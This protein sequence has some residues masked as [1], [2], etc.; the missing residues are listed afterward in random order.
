MFAGDMEIKIL[1]KVELQSNLS[2]KKSPKN[3]KSFKRYFVFC[4]PEDDDLILI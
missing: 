3:L 1:E 4:F 2:Y